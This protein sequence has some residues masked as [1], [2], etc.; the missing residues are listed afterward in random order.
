MLSFQMEDEKAL[1]QM[2]RIMVP[3]ARPL[4]KFEKTFIPQRYVSLFLY[5]SYIALTEVSYMC[6]ITEVS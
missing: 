1:K 2:R 4:P 3:H 5:V 6:L